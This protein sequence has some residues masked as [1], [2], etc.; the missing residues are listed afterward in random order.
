MP[1]RAARPAPTA[2]RHLD[3]RAGLR[4]P[5][6]PAALSPAHGP[7][8]AAGTGPARPGAARGDP[9]HG[10][11]SAAAAVGGGRGRRGGG[12][13][14][15]PRTRV[16]PAERPWEHRAAGAGAR[17]A[18]AGPGGAPRCPG[19]APIPLGPGRA[20]PGSASPCVS[21]RRDA[22]SPGCLAAAPVW[23]ELIRACCQPC[24]PRAAAAS[25]AGAPR[26]HGKV[27]RAP[28]RAR[29]KGLPLAVPHRLLSA[30]EREGRSGRAAGRPASG[31]FSSRWE[32]LGGAP[33]KPRLRPPLPE[34]VP[35]A[36][37]G[38]GLL[39]GPCRRSPVPP[40]PRSPDPRAPCVCCSERT[41]Q[42]GVRLRLLKSR[43]LRSP[44][45]SDA[46]RL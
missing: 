43:K 6:S 10:A 42:A 11:R 31:K 35:G 3:A 25:L 33:R 13:G 32:S 14:S 7:A 1:R 27:P 8:P 12:G 15:A 40:A 4:S 41:G 26:W 17:P 22:E 34:P 39:P 21:R 20:A 37:R 30:G 24:P 23:F 16:P 18:G 9:A 5:V 28:L 19:R 29:P 44:P 46:V 2:A 45:D 36:V 38:W